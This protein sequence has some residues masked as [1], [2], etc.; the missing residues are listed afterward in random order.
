MVVVCPRYQDPSHHIAIVPF[1]TTLQPSHDHNP[2]SL[3]PRQPFH[4]TLTSSSSLFTSDPVRLVRR[5]VRR[6]R[7]AGSVEVGRRGRLASEVG[8]RVKSVGVGR[9]RRSVGSVGLG[10]RVRSF[11]W[12]GSSGT[13]IPARP[14]VFGSDRGRWV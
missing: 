10:R 4:F 1:I 5:F 7:S 8:R 13:L 11:V 14:G 9:R 2:A 12:F 3:S 6:G